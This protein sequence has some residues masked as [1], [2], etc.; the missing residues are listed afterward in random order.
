M[1]SDIAHSFV[2]AHAVPRFS[3]QTA[4]LIQERGL[5]VVLC[6]LTLSF[7]AALYLTGFF[8][9]ICEPC[10]QY[11]HWAI[12]SLNVSA[13]V[14]NI[15]V[16]LLKSGSKPNFNLFLARTLLAISIVL[17]TFLKSTFVLFVPCA[18][19][20]ASIYLTCFYL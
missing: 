9:N 13:V 5:Q 14:F 19:C 8:L 4:K 6:T 11:W 2:G 18:V 3:Q 15:V 12:Y 20:V 17:S 16:T 7:I 1:A 10:N